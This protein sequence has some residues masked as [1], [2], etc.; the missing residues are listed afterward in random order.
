MK[1]KESILIALIF[2]G[3]G[4]IVGWHPTFESVR[5]FV[6]TGL[7][8]GVLIEM[9]G[10]LRELYKEYREEKA[11]E[12]ESQNEKRSI[13]GNLLSEIEANQIRLQPISVNVAKILDSNDELSEED[14]FPNELIFERSIYSALSSKLGLLDDKTRS[15]LIQYY[16]DIKYMEDQYKK[17]EL[18]HGNS[19][20][21]LRY[22]EFKELIEIKFQIIKPG[23]HEIEEFLRHTKNVYEL[24]RDLIMDLTEKTGTSVST[25]YEPLAKEH[26]QIER[27]NIQKLWFDCNEL[28]TQISKEKKRIKEYIENEYGGLPP[29]FECEPRPDG[30]KRLIYE[31]LEEFY[32]KGK[33]SENGKIKNSKEFVETIIK[34]KTLYEIF[35]TVK[36]NEADLYEKANE[37]EQRLKKIVPDFEKRHNELK[38]WYESLK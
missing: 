2:F 20:G 17:L 15:K 31:M 6:I 37:I 23:W 35:E 11:K 12:T 26:S 24:G 36:K 34:D 32:Q 1:W 28:K 18:I 29:D 8:V 27:P 5:N 7:S 14:I 4:F 38:D 10:F 9:G 13:S 25:T 21:F 33:M 22:L 19:Y 16:S 30:K 3:V